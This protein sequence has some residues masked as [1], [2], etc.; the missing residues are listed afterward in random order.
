[1]M[2]N[3]SP[4]SHASYPARMAQSLSIRTSIRLSSA[5]CAAGIRYV[6]TYAQKRRSCSCLSTRSGRCTGWQALSDTHI[7]KRSSTGSTVLK[8]R[9]DMLIS[10]KTSWNRLSAI[11]KRSP[12]PFSK[13]GAS[14]DAH[15]FYISIGLSE[16]YV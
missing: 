13:N 3:A 10:G 9:F 5:I 12:T 7:C 4:V 15:V 6:R 16:F 11:K 14:E 1:M 2:K 8:R